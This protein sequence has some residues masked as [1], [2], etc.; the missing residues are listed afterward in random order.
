MLNPRKRTIIG[1]V[2]MTLMII[3]AAVLLITDKD[4]SADQLLNFSPDN[5]V[6]AVLFLWCLF[7][8]KSLTIVFPS[9]VLFVL[10]GIMFPEI[11]CPSTE[12]D[13]TP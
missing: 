12:I 5:T 13:A 11:D 1:A 3:F 9:L 2:I 4:I 7:A 8:A 6:L 10:G